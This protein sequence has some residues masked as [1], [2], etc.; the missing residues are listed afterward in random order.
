MCRGCGRSRDVKYI[1]RDETRARRLRADGRIRPVTTR[2]LFFL[3]G[4]GAE[5]PFTLTALSHA[6]DGVDGPL[7]PEQ[8]ADDMTDLIVRGITYLDT[9]APEGATAALRLRA[10]PPPPVGPTPLLDALRRP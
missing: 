10:G 8:H 1:Y 7:D 5:A 9:D 6:F 2:G 3:V 4:H